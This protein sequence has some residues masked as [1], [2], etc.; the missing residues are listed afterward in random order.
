MPAFCIQVNTISTTRPIVT[1]SM[2]CRRVSEFEKINA[3]MV[4]AKAV[5][6]IISPVF[7]E[8]YTLS[9]TVP[10]SLLRTRDERIMSVSTE[11]PI[12]MR[13]AATPAVPILT[14]MILSTAMVTIISEKHARITAVL[15]MNVLNIM[16]TT[17]PMKINATIM[18]LKISLK[19]QELLGKELFF[20][21]NVRQNKMFNN[22]ELIIDKVEEVDVE[23][24]IKELESR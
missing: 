16:K 6:V 20:I 22:L 23:G 12:S 7:I 10:S 5:A 11:Y 3:I 19:K 4:T 21:G 24:L 9:S 13:N 8:P 15:G 1:I 18:V 14:S 2:I 17:M